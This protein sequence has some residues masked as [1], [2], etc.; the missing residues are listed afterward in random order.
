MPGF[1]SRLK[2]RLNEIYVEHTGKA[3]KDIEEN[4]ERD[5]FMDVHEAKEYGLI[6][7][8]IT[9]RAQKEDTNE[10]SDN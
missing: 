7:A 1:W 10:S 8:V 3:L 4:L 9:K 5:R 2:Q 6:D